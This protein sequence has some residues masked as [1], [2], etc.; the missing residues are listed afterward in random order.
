MWQ[1]SPIAINPT[2]FDL[3]PIRFETERG[4]AWYLQSSASALARALSTGRLALS[5]V[6]GDLNEITFSTHDRSANIFLYE[7][8]A[9]GCWKILT[10]GSSHVA[11][12]FTTATA[13]HLTSNAEAKSIAT[14]HEAGSANGTVLSHWQTIV[15]SIGRDGSDCSKDCLVVGLDSKCAKTKQFFTVPSDSTNEGQN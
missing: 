4:F 3:F 6:G 12:A 8:F 5:L 2:G 13:F 11:D 9:A 15:S 10:E 7:G 1:P 14:I